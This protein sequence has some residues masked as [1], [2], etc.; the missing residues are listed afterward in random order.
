MSVHAALTLEAV[1]AV[2]AHARISHDAAT[3][4]LLDGRLVLGAS[5]PSGRVAHGGDAEVVMMLVIEAGFALVARLDDG[6]WLTVRDLVPQEEPEMYS[7]AQPVSL[8]SH[9]AA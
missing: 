7:N 9:R 4:A 2:A 3:D 1:T 5:G 6:A 8:A